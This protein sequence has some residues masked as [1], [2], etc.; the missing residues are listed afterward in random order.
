[1]AYDVAA[2]DPDHLPARYALRWITLDA[3]GTDLDAKPID[4]RGTR[5]RRFFCQEREAFIYASRP[6]RM[7][8]CWMPVEVEAPP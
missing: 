6:R 4:R 7:S 8:P 3:S 2:A 1:M 5:A